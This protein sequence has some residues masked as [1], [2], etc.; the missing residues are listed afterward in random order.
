MAGD[1]L[2]EVKLNDQEGRV[3]GRLLTERRARLIETMEDTTQPDPARRAGS[4][5][6]LLVVSILGKLRLRDVTPTGPENVLQRKR[7]TRRSDAGSIN[8]DRRQSIASG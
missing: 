3:V 8:A 1:K 6:L 4:I 7:S 2:L 5:E